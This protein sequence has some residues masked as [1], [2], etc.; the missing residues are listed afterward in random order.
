[1]RII[2]LVSIAGQTNRPVGKLKHERIPA[3]ASPA[4]ADPRSFE[5]DVRATE[6]AQVVAQ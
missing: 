2:A 1:M 5:D 6:P 3:L 4:F